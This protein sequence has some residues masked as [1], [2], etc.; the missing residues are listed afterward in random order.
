MGIRT[1]LTDNILDKFFSES[2]KIIKEEI[3]RALSYL[4]EQAVNLARDRGQDV[5]WIDHTGNLRSSIGYGVFE[6]GKEQIRSAFSQVKEGIDGSTA[7]KRMVEE[8]SNLYTDTYVLVVVAGMNY[9]SY[10]E[11]IE[12]KDVLA[13]ATL[14]AKSKMNTYMDKALERAAKRIDKIEL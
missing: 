5:S 3:V 4:G 14:M 11:A 8:L 1:N 7:G 12:S 6:N 2:S 10:V 9:A 13:T